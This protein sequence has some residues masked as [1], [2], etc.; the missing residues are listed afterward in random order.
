MKISEHFKNR[1][2]SSVRKAQISFSKRNDKDSITVINLAIG[3]ISRPMYPAMRKA[4]LELGTERKSDGVVKYTPT[5][6][7][8]NARNAFLK[9]LSAE[10]YDKT[11]I[12]SMVTDGGSSAMELMLLGVCGPASK[13]P[14]L[15]LD[16]TYTNYI[17][18]ANRLSIPIVSVNRQID[19][20]G[21]FTSLNM[22]S[23]ESIISKEKPNGL[24]FIPYDNPTGQFLSKKV[25]CDLAAIAVKNDI[26]LISDEAYRSLSYVGNEP[27][28]IWALNESD[29][30]GISGR[31][32]SIESASKV[33]NACGLRIG[34]LLT[35]NYEFHQKAISEYTANLCANSL[36]QEVFG[37]MADESPEKILKWQLDQKNYY[38]KIALKL[39]K[40]FQKHIPGIIVTVPE[41][42]IYFILD[43]KNITDNYFTTSKFVDYCAS[44]GK[45][46]L[47]GKYYTVLLAP[48]DGFYT[49]QN[50]GKT[51]VR[52]AMVE[53]EERMMITPII[54]K[55]LLL[56]YLK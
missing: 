43:F 33:W 17:D 56:E 23:I 32:I 13:N 38:M 31:R 37:V 2:P 21:S 19:D 26:W 46:K 27:S 39:K 40:E 55:K 3:N 9:I 45:V 15:F 11:G 6:G 53:S 52:L 14:I 10:G 8:D 54:L 5:V 49:K 51:Q 42:A 35:D 28:S 7:T 22:N 30:R 16:P 4:L 18:F 20:N 48:M 44:D 34:G 29:V 24:L 12:H 1:N 47:K 36:G 25:L 50:F 41:A